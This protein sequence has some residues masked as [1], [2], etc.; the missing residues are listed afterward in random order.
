MSIIKRL[1]L[2]GFKSFAN[3]TVLHFENGFNT[4]VGA[5][6]SGKSNVFDALC[7]VL[8]RMSSKGLRA[9]KLGNL[10]FN[11]GTHQN[12]SKDAEVSIF[13]S[14]DKL[15][16]NE[17]ELLPADIDE[18]KITRIVSKTGAS[19]YLL[20]NE[21]VTRTEIVE[22]L[23]RAHIDPDG[24]NIILQ[25]D[26]T[27]IV[28]MSSIE[29]RQLIEEISQVDE[30]EDKR[31]DSLKKLEGV[32]QDLKNADL[33]LNEKTRYLKEL[34][35][36]KDNAQAFYLAKSQL[37]E[38]SLL[39]IKAKQHRT[40]TQIQTREEEKVV[41]DKELKEQQEKFQVFEKKIQEI[42]DELLKIEKTIEITSHGDFLEITNAIA[43]LE[44]NITNSNQKQ[45]DLQKQKEDVVSRIKG[46]QES[47]TRS[48]QKIQE[49]EGQKKDISQKV[50]QKEK[51]LNEIQ[52]QIQN[53]RSSSGA[54]YTQ[55]LTQ[56][57]E[58]IDS[59]R[60]EI[61]EIETQ[62]QNLL[63]QS[64]RIDT[65]IEYV[66]SQQREEEQK[67]SDNKEQFKQL[68]EMRKRLKTI[69]LEVSKTANSNSEYSSR[70]GN[71]RQEL[72]TLREKEHKLNAKIQQ[73][74][75]HISANRAVEEVLRFKSKDENIIGTVSDLA[76]VDSKYSKALE[77]IA[78]R[79]LSNIVVKN[80][81]TATK[82][83]NYLKEK[84][85][86]SV[87]F[88]PLNKLNVRVQL[89][90]EV[91]SKKG[92]IDYA[93]NI[94]EFDKQYLRV[95]ELLFTDTLVIEHIDYA[96]S[97]GIGSYKMVT[98]DGDIVAKTG[99]MS[100]GFKPKK[101]Q[102]GGGFN[103]Q[104]TKE[105]LS[106]L[107]NRIL[108][109][110][111]SLEEVK[112]MRDES[113]T[114]LYSLREK[115]AYLE[116][117]IGKLEKVLSID[118]KDSDSIKK[119]LEQIQGD[120]QI[121]TSQLNKITKKSD[122]LKD[123]LYKLEH[124]RKEI[125]QS[126]DSSS[127][128]SKLEQLDIQKENIQQEL[129]DLNREKES[130]TIQINNVLEPEIKN[131]N[132]IIQDSQDAQKRLEEQIKSVKDEIAQMNTELKEKKSKEKELSSE[133]EEIINKRNELKEKRAYQEKR[134]SNEYEKFEKVKENYNRV[135]YNLEELKSTLNVYSEEE[136]L[137]LQEIKNDFV[138]HEHASTFDELV[139][140]VNRVLEKE[141]DI[142]KLQEN[143]NSL[144]TKISSFGSINLK[145]VAVYDQIKEEFDDLLER[146]ERLNLEEE[147]IMNFIS[148]MDEK[149]KQKFL[150]TFMVLKEKFSQTYSQLSSKGTA[151]LL[152]ENEKD[153]FNT[154]IEIKVKLSKKNFLD[155][156]SL[157]GGEK[158]ITAVAFIFAVQ[159]FNPA[160]F[161]IFDEID[162]A[163]DIVNCE[164][165]GK[166]IS[167]NASKAQ[168]I[169]VSHSEYL[170][171]SAQYIYGVT[172]DSN[173]V[174][175]VVS[176]D[177][178]SVSGYVDSEEA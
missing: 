167:Q 123:K 141:Y 59:L 54:Q 121:V 112:R 57:E 45:S 93:L 62:K 89:N 176:L 56:I 170:I 76:T 117:E 44:S 47:I 102:S 111:G 48:K 15:E 51:D 101:S 86:G 152:I 95:F 168:Y 55:K 120:K 119:E 127:Q 8:G 131:S 85:V 30:Y 98:L 156:K 88:F 155:I 139:E 42:D 178:D 64:E 172:M 153:L 124:L 175:G 164:K 138:E 65:K 90:K 161:Y 61:Q 103:D 67:S 33:L 165:L 14:N 60:E 171:Q 75:A 17:R 66:E 136:E 150:Q 21:K 1:K 126:M 35:S 79:A 162:A 23:K 74:S 116:G 96:K 22:V 29:R 160:S 115:K 114:Q 50:Q 134:Y 28:S 77:T 107:Q 173:K 73:N 140:H 158:T 166:L 146:R 24:Y 151:E 34:K 63:V 157:S 68:D 99:A 36:E 25:G 38:S 128:I 110:E 84:K 12:A 118:S 2:Q 144:K 145:A 106:T 87:T 174:S 83:I 46:L 18:V 39:L 49:L 92:V 147:D 71:L 52:K 31:Q 3:P 7:F 133:Y 137:L 163:L 26:I 78:G 159:E 5:N 16:N 100:G 177:L 13:L 10:V 70:W 104:K 94:V 69:I 53:S 80:D 72:E 109:V 129:F 27:R 108:T 40:H 6:G 113:E 132:K 105:E 43:R 148:Q 11:G 135:L 4:I 91:L 97:I 154:G 130:Y 169:V 58:E 122:E 19:K 142:K 149:K 143:V 9:D 82:Y 81:T 125:R 41:K 20:N 32:Q 37:Q